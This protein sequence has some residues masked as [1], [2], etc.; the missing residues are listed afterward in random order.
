MRQSQSMF[1]K[2]I[3]NMRLRNQLILI[4]SIQAFI[5]MSYVLA[6]NMIHLSLLNVYF[7]DTSNHLYKESSNRIQQNIIKLYRSYF[8]KVFYLNG[9]TLISFHRLYHHTK[10]Q[11]V[12]QNNFTINEQFQMPY[13]GINPIPDPLRII[14]GYGNFDI[15]YCFMCYSNLSSYSQPKTID[16]LVGIKMQEQV[17]AYGQLLYQGKDINQYFFYS[18]IKK[19]KITSIY[20]CLNREQGI[21]SYKPEQRDWYIE[22][23]R[24]YDQTENY[25]NYNYTFTNPFI[26]FTEKKIGLSMAMP[27]VDEQTKLIGGVGSIFL[28][29]E[30]VQEVGQS[31]FGFQIIYLI[32]NEGI[33]IMHPYK[34]SNEYLPLYIFNQTI[35]GFNQT[36]WEEMKKHNGSSSCPNFDVYNSSMQCRYN[37]VYNQEMIIG[38]Q[39]IAEFKMILITL[40][41]SQEYLEFYYQFQQ[42]LSESL[43]ETLS[44]NIT[45][46][47]ALLILVCLCI[48][49]LIQVLF[50][51]IYVVQEYAKNM[52]SQKKKKEK[53]IPIFIQRLMSNQVR[54]LLQSFKFIEN[55][56]ELLS[57]RKTEQCAY[58][59]SLQFPQKSISFKLHLQQYQNFLKIHKLK[60]IKLMKMQNDQNF[61]QSN[62]QMQHKL[63]LRQ[64]LQLVKKANLDQTS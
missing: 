5:I 63:Y 34:V 4:V 38:I 37:S 64:I 20:P 36:D 48:Y 18:Y 35:T 11:V 30:F 27:I 41:S 55:K 14:K 33:M 21:Y 12:L 29:N 61:N 40:L 46:L 60:K 62:A 42:K 1:S 22:L 31:K 17:Q 43:Q 51:P 54:Q 58:F 56:L 13:G 3:Q 2:C 59:E 47:L 16:E 57:F 10:K 15:S 49:V 23:Q 7:S 26:L 6:Q 32:S 19:E 24:N 39:E 45:T 8:D 50:Y 44:L 52:I 53:T 9:N 28:G 25:K